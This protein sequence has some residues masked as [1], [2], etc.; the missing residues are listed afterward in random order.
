MLGKARLNFE[1]SSGCPCKRARRDNPMVERA[2]WSFKLA[3]CYDSDLC[4]AG[5]ERLGRVVID[6]VIMFW[7]IDGVIAGVDAV[8][9]SDPRL[10]SM[11][12]RSRSKS[13]HSGA[14]RKR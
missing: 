14:V 10:P 2:L 12:R 7:G 11:S 4:Y 13:L 9:V 6:G 8:L 3:S 1:I 5:P